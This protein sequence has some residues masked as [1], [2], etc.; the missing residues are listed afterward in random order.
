LKI[1]SS[2]P[3]SC[4]HFSKYIDLLERGPYIVA[5]KLDEAKEYK[6]LV[7]TMRYQ[8][9]KPIDVS[10][11]DFGKILRQLQDEFRLAM[12]KTIQLCW[13]YSGFESKYIENFGMR[14]RKEERKEI[15]APRTSLDGEIYG[16]VAVLCPSSNTANLSQALQAATKRWKN[17]LYNV[18]TGKQSIPSF[19][20]DGPIYIH[21][22]SISLNKQGSDYYAKLSLLS[23]K[24]KKELGFKTA[25]I[26]VL[27]A[28][29]DNTKRVI[30]Q[31]IID[32]DYKLNSCMVIHK[33]KWFL[34]VN[35]AFEP[36][37]VELD[38]NNF[39]GID[40]G[41]KHPI[42]VAFNNSLKRFCIDGG[43]I[44]EHRRRVE[45]RKRQL[46]RQGKYCG[47]SRIGHGIKK[48]IEPIE[49]YSERIANFRDTVNH[50]Y[51]KKII[52]LAVNNNCGVIQM[53]DL[54]G[55]S[56]DD[57]FLRNWSYFD[58]QTKIEYK[59]QEVGIVVSY[60]NPRYTS[61]RCSECGHIES[62]NRET[63]AVF[64]CLKCGFETNADFNAA[65]N[66][67]TP[68]IDQIIA[69]TRTTSGQKEEMVE[70][71][72]SNDVTA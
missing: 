42:Y 70:K 6:K 21:N 2:N 65:R 41:I 15:F 64:K 11:S 1:N 63:Q 71:L 72:D 31:R 54:T 69:E 52:E 46:L 48:R 47:E 34:M 12:N 53:E 8:I 27:L 58:L 45:A 51:S 10:W 68:L 28:T 67:A 35:Y 60:I 26:Q 4:E 37:T 61:Q 25:Q 39:M 22:N 32:G 14:P 30:A 3:D 49:V 56:K 33:K 19:K 36:K 5:K 57:K 9:I 59:A 62:G 40:L 66:I 44:E 17:D 29:P 38:T 43:K 24:F 13:E 18:A 16:Q 55:I 23:T 20:A 7:K 50:E